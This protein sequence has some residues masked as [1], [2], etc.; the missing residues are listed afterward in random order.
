MNEAV[1]RNH[2]LLQHARS[3]NIRG[4]TEALERGA[5]TETRRPLV[6]RPQKEERGTGT[7]AE[8]DVGMTALMFAAQ[9]GSLECVRRL[10][11]ANAAVNALEED[12]WT[13]LHFA[14]SEGA[15]EVC[16]TL[17]VAK[18]D[19]SLKNHDGNTPLQLAEGDTAK[20]LEKATATSEPAGSTT[21][22]EGKAKTN[23]D[24]RGSR[25]Q[26]RDPANEPPLLDGL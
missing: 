26:P 25:D 4:V 16:R 1:L 24:G 19:A 3:G 18:A 14:A 9:V 10:L 20:V 21:P 2:E 6:M 5:W 22:R 13:P 15:A 11:W 12:G 7:E 23:S 17:L 8:V